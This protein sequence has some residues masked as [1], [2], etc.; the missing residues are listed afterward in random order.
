[1]K[2]AFKKTGGEAPLTVCEAS[3]PPGSG[4]ALHRHATYDEMHIA[5]EGQHAFQ[6]G[7]EMLT[8]EPG[9][10]VFVPSGTPH[11]IRVVGPGNGSQLIISTPAGIFE[12]FVAEV[13]AAEEVDGDSREAAAG[14]QLRSRKVWNPSSSMSRGRKRRETPDGRHG[15]T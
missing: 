1:V 14:R 3:G 7:E 13:A 5:T 15:T 10:M 6:L 4:A 12:A 8:L 2:I 9:D 11:S